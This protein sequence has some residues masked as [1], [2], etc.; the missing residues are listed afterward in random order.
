[1]K[2]FRMAGML[3]RLAFG[4]WMVIGVG[5]GAQTLKS[6]GGYGRD[7]EGR[8]VRELGGA[9]T[10]AVVLYFVASDCPI[11]NRTF[12]EM[13]RVREEFSGG[14]V[15]FWF[16]YANNGETAAAVKEHQRQYDA[17]G[18]AVLDTDGM[19]ARMTGA[20]VTPEVAVLTPDAAGKEARWSVRYVG[21]VDDRYVRIGVER[22]QAT[23]H[24]AERVVREVLE[25]KPVEKATGMPV[26]CG[27]V[28]P[29]AAGTGR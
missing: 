20:K 25:G 12:P 6:A 27:I 21:R 1:M 18:E 28:S 3:A 22:S 2:A 8:A 4:V 16:V 7:I 17:E 23:E 9:S 13:K 26:G 15:R 5:L 24:F 14:G 10:R 29:A 11:S 19:L